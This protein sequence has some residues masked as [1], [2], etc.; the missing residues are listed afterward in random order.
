MI[1][2]RPLIAGL[3]LLAVSGS[4]AFAAPP[5]DPVARGRAVFDANCR[6][7][8]GAGIGN[9]GERFRPGTAALTVKYNGEKP[10]LLEERTDLTPEAVAWFVRNGA[11]VMAPYRKTEVSNADLAALGAY[12][13]R[14]NPDLRRAGKNKP[15]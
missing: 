15:R 5:Q 11:T 12:L 6:A 8:H 14:N 2:R 3:A 7:C 4:L 1:T 13:S 9:P 10:G